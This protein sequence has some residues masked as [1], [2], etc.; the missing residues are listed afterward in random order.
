MAPIESVLNEIVRRIV[1]T[2]HPKRIILFGSAVRGN[3]GPDSDLDLLIVVSSGE[4]RRKTA[5]KIYRNLIGVGFATDIVVVTEGDLENY[6]DCIDLVIQ[7]ALE[8]GRVLYA[9]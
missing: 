7:P 5:Q 6:K 8:E 1:E 2:V 3:M 9:A 4:H